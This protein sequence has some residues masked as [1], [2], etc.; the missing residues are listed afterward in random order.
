MNEIDAEFADAPVPDMR[1]KRRLSQI[2]KQVVSEPGASFPQIARSDGELEAIYRFL[3]NPR[4]TLT[5]I[6][7][8]HLEATFKRARDA[9][10]V[11]VAHDSTQ[12]SFPKDVGDELG[13]LPTSHQQG[14][15]GHFA[16]VMNETGQALGIGGVKP[17]FFEQHRRGVRRGT[18]RDRD[19]SGEPE[20]AYSR[21]GELVDE[22]HGRLWP[23]VEAVHVMDREGDS[24]RL[25]GKMVQ[26]GDRFV[27]RIKRVNDRPAAT[28]LDDNEE[29]ET[30]EEVLAE[31]TYVCQREV[32]LTRRKPRA[33][34]NGH[35]ARR[36]RAAT[37][38][39]STTTHRSSP[40]KE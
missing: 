1:L 33:L 23:G 11:I 32:E 22:V 39:L 9:K 29:W 25:V 10:R 37:L 8:P 18:W 17:Y 5:Q 31:T 40:A 16:L 20:T 35:P 12:F 19:Y 3:N 38:A 36:G 34:A 15:C 21:W 26:D 27:V 30:L 4:V 2:A 14:F 7:A 13:Y 24:Y 28:S 6:V